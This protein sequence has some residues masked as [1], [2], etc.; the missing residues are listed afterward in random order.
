VIAANY[1]RHPDALLAQMELRLDDAAQY[2][3]DL[4]PAL[5]AIWTRLLK[6]RKPAQ[7]PAMPAWLAEVLQRARELAKAVKSACMRLATIP[8]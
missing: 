7:K 8:L 1:R 6:A 4:T 3:Q 5:R 2:F